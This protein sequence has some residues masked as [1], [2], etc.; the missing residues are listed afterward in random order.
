MESGVFMT[1]DEAVEYTHSLLR[2]GI[3]PGLE[4]MKYVTERLGLPQNGF[5]IVHV[6]G[7]NGKGSTVNMISAALSENG[8]KTGMF[9][10]PY[11]VDFRE[12]IQIDGD[13]IEKADYAEYAG[14]VKAV[15]D[16][17]DEAIGPITEFEFIT[18]VA[19][20]YFCEK[21]CDFAVIEVGL[22]GRLDATNVVENPVISVITD[23]SLDHTDIL[24]DTV[25][26]IAY[27]KCGIIKE[28]V[29]VV[30]AA[31]QDK[32]AL[33]VIK[34]CCFDRGAKLFLPKYSELC[35]TTFGSDG[36]SFCCYG[37]SF[38]LPMYGSY[39]PENALTA[40]TA[41][42]V[43]KAEYGVK[44]DGDAVV[45]AFKRVKIP[46]RFEKVRSDYGEFILDCTHNPAGA[47]TLADTLDAAY[48]GQ[49]LFAV[50]GMLG[51][52]NVD[53]VLKK[54]SPHISGVIT[55]TPENPRAMSA[56]ELAVR[57]KEYGVPAFSGAIDTETL[58]N[59]IGRSNGA[60]V[61]VFGSFYTVSPFRL[62]LIK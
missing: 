25:E 52:Q 5:K 62:L 49:K 42:K 4:R 54:V 27:E 45:S 61:L 23:V 12:R 60:P 22:G 6:A 26:K 56:C 50:C 58:K 16:T 20:L 24:G 46:G 57:F 31:K 35:N 17:A 34:K 39:V 29:P 32:R 33:E 30:T 28:N 37:K 15:C 41:L 59:A 40:L 53:E 11:V 13:F 55:V 44:I 14:R 18:A 48:P 2:F 38:S 9:T 1:Y 8:Y 21:K 47:E 43:L 36:A 3:K 19:F 10:S 7:T 51:D